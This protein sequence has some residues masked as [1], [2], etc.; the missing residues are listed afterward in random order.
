MKLSRIEGGL[1]EGRVES[2]L[3][4]VPTTYVGK[5]MLHVACCIAGLIDRMANSPPFLNL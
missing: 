4:S 2:F 1:N 5:Y 3:Y